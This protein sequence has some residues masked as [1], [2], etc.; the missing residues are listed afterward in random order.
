[1]TVSRFDV[2]DTPLAGL[3]VVQRK[4]IRDARGYFSRF[5][6]AEEFRQAG[7]NSRIAQINH[8]HSKIA[9][10]VRGMHYQLP[11]HAETKFVSCIRGEIFDVAVDLRRNSPTFLQWH[12]EILSAENQ[13]SLLIPE[14]F[15]HGFQTLTEDCEL[16]YLVS[17]AYAPTAEG[18]VNA[19]DPMLKIEWPLPVTEMSE[20]DRSVL[21]LP[22][23][24]TGIEMPGMS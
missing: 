22:F 19:L 9:G 11:P 20:K 1:M 18:G 6:C 3:K 14:G 8:S 12:G 10:T 24:Y 2:I 5:F 16:L 23:D 13:R 21:F 17:A 7:L 15:A 4:P